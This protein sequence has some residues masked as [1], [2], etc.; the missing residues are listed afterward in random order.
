MLRKNNS[1]HSNNTMI[2]APCAPQPE[3]SSSGSSRPKR[4]T[5]KIDGDNEKGN[6]IQRE[7]QNKVRNIFVCL[8]MLFFISSVF[9]VKF[10]HKTGR[11]YGHHLSK[12]GLQRLRKTTT[13]TTHDGEGEQQ[14]VEL[15][16]HNDVSLPLNSIYRLDVMDDTDHIMSLTKFMGMVTLVVNVACL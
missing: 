15:Q 1:G 9:I 10:H 11:Y 13:T 2:C 16:Q 3:S 12:E 4:G 5:K 14:Q 8:G 7:N 6:K